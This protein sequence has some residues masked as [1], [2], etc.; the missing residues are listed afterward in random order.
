LDFLTAAKE[1]CRTLHDA[2]HVAYFAG[3]YVRD[4]LLG[5]PSQDIDIATDADPDEI[6][7]LFP[8]HVLVGAHFGVV[9][10]MIGPF[11][12]EVATFRKDLAY[13]DGRHPEEVVL[14]STPREDAARRDF[15]INGMFYDPETA[16]VI[17]YVGGR[18]DLERKII[19]TIGS[20]HERFLEDRLR[21]LR[22]VRFAARFTFALAEETSAAIRELAPCLIPAVSMERIWL[23]FTKMREDG[24]FVRA[25]RDL[26]DLGLLGT[27]FPP[28]QLISRDEFQK[29]ISHFASFSKQVPSILF[30][31]ELFENKDS[32]YVRALPQYLKISNIESA[33]IETML[34]IR[35]RPLESLEPYDLAYLFANKHFEICFDVI[36]TKMAPE[37]RARTIEWYTHQKDALEFFVHRIRRKEPLVRSEDLAALGV[38]PGKEMGRLLK[39]CE[40]MSINN[41]IKEKET[42]VQKLLETDLKPETPAR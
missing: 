12:F 40:K 1:L 31:V 13:K 34:T 38:V 21:M 5:I 9:L 41:N 35:S 16:I 15:T 27:I 20:P 2:G 26:F 32:E 10:V 42:I 4:L 36:L 3:G 37:E 39:V 11:Q 8:D 22:A 29:R 25:L 7:A 24:H 23:E 6:V 14:K 33:W 19:R 17:D 18:V 28:L 30:I